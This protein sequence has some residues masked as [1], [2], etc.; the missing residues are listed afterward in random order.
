MRRN[1]QEANLSSRRIT[2]R[3]LVLGGLQL[4]FGGLLLAR[5]QHL[6]VDQADEF[7]LLAEE[8]RIK[9]RLLAPARGVIYDRNGTVLAGNEQIYPRQHDPRGC[10]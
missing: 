5:M 3:A 2:R 7:L 1:A 4:G 8:N 10:R 6:Q 9:V